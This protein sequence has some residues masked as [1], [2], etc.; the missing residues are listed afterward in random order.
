MAPPL[1]TMNGWL[2][3]NSFSY[4]SVYSNVLL[5]QKTRGMLLLF[6]NSS[7]ELA[8]LAEKLASSKVPSKSEK[9]TL[10]INSRQSY[11]LNVAF[12]VD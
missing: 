9:T 3:L 2:M 8:C 5:V 4:S 12:M 7:A 6:N 10:I 11:V 1:S